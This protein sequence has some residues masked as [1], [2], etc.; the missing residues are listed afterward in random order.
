MMKLT[1]I[2]IVSK[3]DRKKEQTLVL[4]KN[5]DRKSMIAPDDKKESSSVRLTL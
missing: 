4:K 5:R 3:I 2:R 1:I